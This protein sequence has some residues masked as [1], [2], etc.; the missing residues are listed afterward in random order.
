VRQVQNWIGGSHPNPRGAA[1][2]PPPPEDVARLLSDLCD[3]CARDDL[4]T[5]AQAAVAH[6][7]FETIHPYFDGNGRVGRVLVQVILRRRGLART[8]LPPV[9]LVLAGAGERYIDGLTAFRRGDAEA[10]LAFFVE[11]AFRA[12]RAGEELADGV[13]ALQDEWIA[14]AG[15]PRRDSAASTLVQ[16]LPEEPIVDLAAARRLTGA[17]AQATLGGIDRLVGAGVLHELSGRRRGRLWESAG[18]FALLDRF[19]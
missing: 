8:V 7:Q 3:F 6:V 4:P 18:L 2:I 17:S 15:H 19:E 11:S 9:S 1:F 12:A 16:R 5:I 13:R 10:W 14:R